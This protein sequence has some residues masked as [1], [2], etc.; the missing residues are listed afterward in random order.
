MMLG[1]ALEA[2]YSFSKSSALAM[3][4]G[5]FSL[6]INGSIIV[7][8]ET[9]E[10]AAR[11]VDAPTATLRNVRRETRAF[12]TGWDAGACCFWVGDPGGGGVVDCPGFFS[13][14]DIIPL[15]SRTVFWFE[16]L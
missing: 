13:P 7:P 9:I 10:A 8:D 4:W 2:A 16:P 3:T 5:S 12:F 6:G 14:V 11:T 1:S 15:L